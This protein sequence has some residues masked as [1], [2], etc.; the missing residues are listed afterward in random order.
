MTQGE[1]GDDKEYASCTGN[2][3]EGGKWGEQERGR[4]RT[5]M[6]RD[7]RDVLV[8]GWKEENEGSRREEGR[9]QG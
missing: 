7:T 5:G 1:N 6:I 9:E 2:R 8:V 4:E 3:M